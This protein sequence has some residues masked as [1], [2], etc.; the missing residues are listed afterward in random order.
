MGEDG[1]TNSNLLNLLN[2]DKPLVSVGVEHTI[3]DFV[4]STLI[5]LGVWFGLSLALVFVKAYAYK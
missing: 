3:K 4:P 1:S 2:Q 5:I